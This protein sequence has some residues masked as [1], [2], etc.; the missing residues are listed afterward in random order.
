MDLVNI[1]AG[2]DNII[3]G[4]CCSAISSITKTVSIE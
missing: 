3:E 2:A 1:G 4:E